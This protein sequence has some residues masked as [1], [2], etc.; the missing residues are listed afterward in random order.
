MTAIDPLVQ[1][2]AEAIWPWYSPGYVYDPDNEV[3]TWHYLDRAAVAAAVLVPLIRAQV[4]ADIRAHTEWG[5]R[6]AGVS[7]E[8]REA[9]RDGRDEAID[10]AA[11]IAEG[12]DRG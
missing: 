8:V 7:A 1:A 5:D 4:A 3:A 9:Y 2:V 6:W 12:T 11:R 10:H